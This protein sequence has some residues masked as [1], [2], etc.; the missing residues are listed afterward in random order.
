MA[1]KDNTLKK[2]LMK[3][4]ERVL[5][6]GFFMLGPE[7]ENF[8]KEVAAYCGT[9]FAVGM[10]S[11]TDSLY[12][13][14]RSLNIGPGDEVITTPMSWIATLNAIVLCGATPVFVDVK[15]D[16]NINEDLI[17]AAITSR[18]KAI[19]PVHFTGRMCDIL[20]VQKIAQRHQLHLVEDAA[21]AFG[22][23][24]PEGLAGSFGII[25]C[26]SLNP[27]KILGG[28]GEA[29]ITVTNDAG[30]ADRMKSMRYGGTINREDCHWP[31]L[32]G[33]LD[34][35]QAAMISVGWKYLNG[36]IE[37]NRQIAKRYNAGL[38]GVV[39]CPPDAA[40]KSSHV[41]YSYA[42]LGDRRDELK[43]Y[44]LKNGVETKI[45]HPILMPYH[46]AYKGKFSPSIPVAERQVKRLL[47]LPMDAA[48]T[49]EQ[50]DY[51]IDQVKKFYGA[52]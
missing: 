34:A 25:G 50:I 45:Q 33:R 19:L 35:I 28:Y 10:N 14:L 30:L 41:Y 51:V 47:C 9:K 27:M 26:F 15:E 43:E 23:M 3:A 36:K 7:V 42:I 1:I 12:L 4:V 2:E 24:I 18:T 49:D 13:A 16:L 52:K 11:G 31:S 40:I 46:T 20:R 22:A 29:G 5:D 8:E 37:K 39:G 21:Q 32:N 17:E 6:H 38:N 44:L 48:L